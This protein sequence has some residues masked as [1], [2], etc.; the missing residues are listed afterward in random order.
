[1]PALLATFL[2]GLAAFAAAVAGFLALGLS[3]E[4][5]WQDAC[6][7]LRR[8]RVRTTVQGLGLLS[9]LVSLGCCAG[10]RA[11][12]F[13]FVP[14]IGCVTAAAWVA[15]GLLSHGAATAARVVRLSGVL[16]AVGCVVAMVLRFG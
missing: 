7:A 8:P 9:L 2:L 13:G 4:R 12:G 11:Q 1:M 10:L 6:G 16:A 15:I 14:W 3:M 5:H